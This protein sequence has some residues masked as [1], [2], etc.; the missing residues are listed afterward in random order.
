MLISV[1]IPSLNEA[2]CLP[3]LLQQLRELSRDEQDQLEIIVVDGG[4]KDDTV[5]LCE[6]LVDSVLQQ[7]T[8]RALQMNA[9]GRVAKGDIL[10]FLHAD[11]RLPD[12]VFWCWRS[13]SQS[14]ESWAFFP[15]RLGG[16]AL[17]YRIIE[18]FMNQRSRL[19]SIATGDQT[20]CLKRAAY[21][22]L[23][24]FAD[25]ELMEDIE[26]CKRLKRLSKP[27]LYTSKVHCSVR[28][29]QRDGVV[30]TVLSMWCLRTA[31][32]FG[33]SPAWVHRKYYG[34]HQ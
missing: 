20:L 30:K 21:L 24:G 10:V 28:R 19:S 22:E 34:R 25:I 31:Y 15:V 32:F 11:T 27:M 9:G 23:G 13:L 3:S 2:Q 29:W 18:W 16:S 17:A 4:S 8:G 5:A 12:D 14:D 7:G 1:I 6:P 26:L 33:A